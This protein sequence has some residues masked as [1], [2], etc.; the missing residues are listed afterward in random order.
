MTFKGHLRSQ[1]VALF[2]IIHRE[3]KKGDT[4]LLSISLLNIDRFSQFFYRRTQ[5]R[6]QQASVPLVD[7]IVNHV[8]LQSGPDLNHVALSTRSRPSLFSGRLDLA[9]LHKSCNSLGWDLGYSEATDQVRWMRASP[10]AAA[11]LSRVP[12]A[13]VHCL[14]GTFHKVV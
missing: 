1:I 7:G 8:L 11:W 3:S 12:S 9:S 13:P 10:V 4:I 6:R 5:L 14:V 2:D